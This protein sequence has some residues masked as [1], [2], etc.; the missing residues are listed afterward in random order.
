[1]PIFCPICEFSM[2]YIKDINYFERFQCCRNCAMKFAEFQQDLWQ[3]GWRPAPDAVEEHKK[4][5][6]ENLMIIRNR[7]ES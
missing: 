1:M 3:S 2:S 7:D 6:I 4:Q 5:I